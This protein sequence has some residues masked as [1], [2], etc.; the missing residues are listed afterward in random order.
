MDSSVYVLRTECVNY[1][2]IVDKFFALR[3]NE[4][5]LY[6]NCIERMI[7]FENYRQKDGL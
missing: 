5:V 4:R 6:V 2:Q 7:S 1:E 3:Y